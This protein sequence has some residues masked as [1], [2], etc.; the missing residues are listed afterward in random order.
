MKKR[1]IA[2]NIALEPLDER[3]AERPAAA[4]ND[5]GLAPRL[6]SRFNVNGNHFQLLWDAEFMS[7]L[8]SCRKRRQHPTLIRL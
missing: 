3:P 8:D 6:S 7:S 4:N 5:A 1:D 2:A